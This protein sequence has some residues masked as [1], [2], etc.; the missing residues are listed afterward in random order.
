MT[1]QNNKQPT[2]KE[3][4]PAQILIEPKGNYTTADG[5]PLAIPFT[6]YV[7]G[8]E[9]MLEPGRGYTLGTPDTSWTLNGEE[10]KVT[11]TGGSLFYV[12]APGAYHF[13]RSA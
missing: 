6:I 13:A 2:Y 7:G 4:N 5:Q 9:V 11:Y 3:G 1:Y 8:T 10:N 12:T